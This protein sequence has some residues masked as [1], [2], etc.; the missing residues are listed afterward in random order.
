MTSSPARKPGGVGRAADRA[1]A[2]C[3]ALSIRRL[4]RPGIWTLL[5]RRQQPAG[6]SLQRRIADSARLAAWS[7]DRLA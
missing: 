6:K 2:S 5:D 3:Q 4:A 7:N 1:A